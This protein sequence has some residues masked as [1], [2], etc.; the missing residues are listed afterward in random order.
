[1]QK[2]QKKTLS[3]NKATKKNRQPHILIVEDEHPM[4][5]ALLLKLEN[6]GYAVT[7]AP[8]GTA[9]LDILRT[10]TIDCMLLDLI[11]PFKDGF[12]LLREIRGKRSFPVI[13]LSNLSQEEDRARTHDLGATDF[14]VKSDIQLRDIVARINDIFA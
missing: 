8:H 3:L 5:E 9:A 13:V 10:N 14:L 2:K 6:E 4:A 11:M 7:I 1:M 12:E